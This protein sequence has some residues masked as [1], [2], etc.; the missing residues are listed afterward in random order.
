MNKRPTTGRSAPRQ[1]G[2]IR[3]VKM[4]ELNRDQE[5]AR[6]RPAAGGLEW[7]RM[8]LHLH[9]PASS[10][11]RDPGISY[12]DILKKAEEKGLDMIAFAD[13]NT[14]AG[15]AAMHR[16]V[17]TLTL[18]E[19]LGRATDEERTTLSEYRRLLAKITVLPGFEFTATFGFHILGIFPENMSVRKLEYLLLNLNVPE[20]KMLIGAPDAGSTSDV[21]NS[22][23][24][25]TAAGGLAI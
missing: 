4:Q 2:G 14:V 23:Q 11:Y 20:E 3:S 22:Y 5:A 10:D 18:L 19:R 8:D 15:Y 17:E 21:L 7:K 12:L 9:T 6:N 1:H 13:H 25:I 24:A 16:E